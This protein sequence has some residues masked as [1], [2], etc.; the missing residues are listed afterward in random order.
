LTRIHKIFCF[1]GGVNINNR[2][3]L[4]V[5]LTAVFALL[6][7]F[8]LYDN[9]KPGTITKQPV[10]EVS[11][12]N[13]NEADTTK[14]MILEKPVVING[15]FEQGGLGWNNDYAVEKDDTGNHYIIN[16]NSWEIRQDLDLLPHTTYEICIDTKKGTAEGPARIVFTFHDVNG[17]K[18]NQFY[19]IKYLHKGA[20]WESIPYQFIAIPKEAAISRIYLLSTDPKGYHY[21]DNINLTRVGDV[22][23]RKGLESST[24]DNELLTNGDFEMGLYGWIG[25]ALAIQEE[26]DNRYLSNSYNWEIFQ[27]IDVTPGHKYLVTAKTRR[28]DTGKPARIK[29]IFMDQADQRIPEF[30][31]ILHMHEADTWEDLMELIQ[32]PEN[33]SHARIYLLADD[34][35]G[36]GR[37]DFDN[38]SL[39]IFDE[40]TMP[41]VPESVMQIEKSR[42]IQYVVEKGDT[43]LDIALKFEIDVQLLIDENN[44]IDP[45]RIEEGQIL[46]IPTQE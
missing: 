4:A 44:I 45:N 18:L 10:A 25:E 11:E 14:T 42:N 24:D 12:G 33:V 35:N 27:Q 23:D 34:P 6:A 36:G 41:N 15:D 13:Q 9:F 39:K 3:I 2:V 43:A 31:N 40:E 8:L 19:D 46:Y 37:C 7:V 5:I 28:L 1:E 29:V 17:K 21:F 32:A 16:N 30:Y 20:D 22:G 26:E 38:L